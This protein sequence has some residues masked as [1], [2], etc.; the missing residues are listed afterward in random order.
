MATTI[1]GAVLNTAPMLLLAKHNALHF[2]GYVQAACVHCVEETGAA[3]RA[4]WRRRR[5]RGVI[6]LRIP[7]WH[8]LTNDMLVSGRRKQFW[9]CEYTRA[10][11]R[12][13]D[14]RWLIRHRGDVV[15]VS[16]R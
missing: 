1:A 13:L 12:T 14:R 10:L 16:R 5:R 8:P 9:P 7:H 11:K 2:A 4:E 6:E 3:F 15:S